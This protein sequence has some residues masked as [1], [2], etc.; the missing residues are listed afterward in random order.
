MGKLAILCKWAGIV[1]KIVFAHLGLELLLKC[2]ELAL[3][4][5]EIIVV[6]LL[7]EVLQDLTRWVV[8]VSWST[9]GVQSLTLILRLWLALRVQ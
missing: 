7:S 4:T 1:L 8:E 6:R 5:V 9:F 3:V 2:I